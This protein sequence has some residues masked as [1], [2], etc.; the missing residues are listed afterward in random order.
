MKSLLSRIKSG[1]ELGFD[2]LDKEPVENELRTLFDNLLDNFKVSADERRKISFSIDSNDPFITPED[3][4]AFAIAR[5]TPQAKI[6]HM[7]LYGNEKGQAHWH[8]LYASLDQEGNI[9]RIILCD[10]RIRDGQALTA[11]PDSQNNP[12]LREHSDK[13][14]IIPGES[15][16]QNTSV[17]WIYC[18]AN[19]ASL[20]SIGKVYQSKTKHLGTELGN[21]ME[22]NNQ[23]NS[24]ADNNPPGE[25]IQK[26][27][28][29]APNDIAQHVTQQQAEKPTAPPRISQAP[30]FT[31]FPFKFGSTENPENKEAATQ[32]IPELNSTPSATPPSNNTA[33]KWSGPSLLFAGSALLIAAGLTLSISLPIS[34]TLIVIGVIL[35]LVGAIISIVNN[36]KEGYKNTLVASVTPAM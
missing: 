35:A 2:E 17:C 24:T 3:G 31:L 4:F 16:P 27:V 25:T 32:Q 21:M 30:S 14:T 19:L 23:T 22:N 20:V 8:C 11:Y 18:L 9:E 10:S 12:F 33:L 26:S 6:C 1:K 7:R 34:S 28:N 13:V 29:P 36:V 5:K 15:Q